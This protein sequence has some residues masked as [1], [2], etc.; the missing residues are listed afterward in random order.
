[1]SRRLSHHRNIEKDDFSSYCVDVDSTFHKIT[2]PVIR[3]GSEE[4]SNT[5]LHCMRMWF[6]SLT[7]ST[8]SRA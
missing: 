5:K 7:T 2:P 4:Q 3:I 1:V 6:Y 8:F